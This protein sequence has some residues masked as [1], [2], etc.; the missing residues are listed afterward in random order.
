MRFGFVHG[1]LPFGV[2]C[3][4]PNASFSE[5]CVLGVR[6]NLRLENRSAQLKAA[7]GG[8]TSGAIPRLKAV[9]KP[10]IARGFATV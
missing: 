9:R 7:R 1:C 4:P 6:E 2:D 5:N 8:E 10:R 3:E